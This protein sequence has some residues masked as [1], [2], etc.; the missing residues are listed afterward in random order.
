MGQTEAL[1][2][3]F[4][5]WFM[6][7]ISFF[8]SQVFVHVES[9]SQAHL[10]GRVGCTVQLICGSLSLVCPPLLHL[11]ISLKLNGLYII[12]LP[13][14]GSLLLICFGSHAVAS[15]KA[16]ETQKPE[17]PKAVAA[18]EPQPLEPLE[19]C[20]VPLLFFSFLKFTTSATTTSGTEC[21]GVRGVLLQRQSAFYQY[22]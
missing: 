7:Y 11:V 20:G 3:T 10:F 1:S 14:M 19:L 13:T 6:I 4:V 5:L 9:T 17:D 22:P 8:V 16:I 2:I 21:F 18:G 15:K 12:Q